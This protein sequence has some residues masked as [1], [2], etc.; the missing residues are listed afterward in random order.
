MPWSPG[1]SEFEFVECDM[2]GPSSVIVMNYSLI[3]GLFGV[4][5]SL[6]YFTFDLFYSTMVAFLLFI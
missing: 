6:E 4:E 3:N 1:V 5:N 2:K